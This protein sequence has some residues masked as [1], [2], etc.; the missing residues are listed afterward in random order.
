MKTENESVPPHYFFRQDGR[1]DRRVFKIRL[2][3]PADSAPLFAALE[4]MERTAQPARLDIRAAVGSR[5][6]ASTGS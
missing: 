2:P 6:S 5:P 1:A 4:R 3:G